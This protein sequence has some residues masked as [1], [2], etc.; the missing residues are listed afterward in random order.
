MYPQR[1]FQFQ[2]TTAGVRSGRTGVIAVGMF[3]ALLATQGSS[4]A[5]QPGDMAIRGPQVGE[6]IAPKVLETNLRELTRAR[7]VRPW[8]SGDPVRVMGQ[9]RNLP[10]EYDQPPP[11]LSASSPGP[12]GGEPV[13]GQPVRPKT[14]EQNLLALPE[15]SPG[16][17]GGEPV[18]GH[19]VRPKTLEQNLL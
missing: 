14:L 18:P 3:A 10:P 16:P 2:S 17:A 6:R 15:P 13:P 9:R 4:A 12:A 8:Q 19:P 11:T 1:A 7:I 5:Q